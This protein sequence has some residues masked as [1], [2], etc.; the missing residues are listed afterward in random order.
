MK[1]ILLFVFF[2]AS[3]FLL[4]AQHIPLNKN[5]APQPSSDT[6]HPAMN[7]AFRI[8]VN[9]EMIRRFQEVNNVG[10]IYSPGQ[11]L[12]GADAEFIKSF[13]SE[14]RKS[15]LNEVSLAEI[16]LASENKVQQV[17]ESNET[18]LKTVEEEHTAM[19]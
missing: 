2:L 8:Q 7:P 9:L 19:K 4:S 15:N 12:N 16:R 10:G 3:F 6:C 1:G 18:Q 17:K 13:A 14:Y 11:F 5:T